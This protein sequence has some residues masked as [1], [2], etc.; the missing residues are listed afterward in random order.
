MEFN[1]DKE[2]Y[3]NFLNLRELLLKDGWKEESNK[4]DKKITTSLLTKNG[5]AIH[6]IYGCEENVKDEIL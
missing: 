6:V 5:F 3:G 1:A 2:F 4:R